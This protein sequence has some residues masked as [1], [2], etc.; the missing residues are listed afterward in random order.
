MKIVVIGLG[1]MGQNH[2]RVLNELGFLH[3]VYDVDSNKTDKISKQYNVKGYNNLD[4]L[5]RDQSFNSVSIVVPT[6]LHKEITCKCLEAGLHVFLEKP[7]SDSLE[8]SN[9]I[10]LTAEKSGKILA[11]GYIE[12]YNPAVIALTE[13]V[14]N[15]FFGEI[16]SI[17]MKR[18]GGIPRSANNIILD[19]MTHD[20]N[21]LISL[22]G[23]APITT[24]T[25]KLT[26]DNIVDSAQTLFDFNG[27]SA[28]CE[29]NWISPIKVRRIEV[30]GT[31]GYAVV[32]LISQ[33]VTEIKKDHEVTRKYF[34][35]PLK[36]ELLA[37]KAAIEN[38]ISTNIVT[39]KDAL[40]TLEV[41]LKAL[42]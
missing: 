14:N 8:T 10:L 16:T 2:V 3:G 39:G 32:D 34:G 15:K 28:T 40:T 13:L 1:A 6:P 22:F 19:L 24:Q 41:T 11:L 18:V 42:G 27:V 17:N 21:I 31:K 5:L 36:N 25:I 12:R 37:F 26:H 29:T 4:S 38:N 35:E 30:T 20:I 23:R 9:D 7:I 33:T